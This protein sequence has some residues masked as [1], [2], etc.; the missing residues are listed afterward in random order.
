MLQS[1]RL[2]YLLVSILFIIFLFSSQPLFSQYFNVYRADASEY[3]TVKLF[4]NVHN[5]YLA[6]KEDKINFEDFSVKENGIDMQLFE[7][8]TQ[9]LIRKCEYLEEGIPVSVAF[10]LDASATMKDPVSSGSGIKFDH[11]KEAAK[12]MADS[13]N[14]EG[15]SEAAIVG[16]TSKVIYNN[17][18]YSNR[19]E[20]KDSIDRMVIGTTTD[21]NEVFESVSGKN[22]AKKDGAFKLFES[23]KENT[24]RIII[25]LSDGK[26]ESVGDPFRY[27]EFIQTSI[28][29][30]ITVFAVT[31]S[32]ENYNDLRELSLRTGGDYFQ[33]Q[34]G[35]QLKE[36]YKQLFV[37]LSSGKDKCWLEYT[38]PIACLTGNNTNEVVV[39][40]S[41]LNEVLSS[42]VTYEPPVEKL[43]YIE[44]EK[45]LI[46]FEKTPDKSRVIKVTSV[47]YAAD[48]SFSVEPDDGNFELPAPMTFLKDKQ[49]SLIVKYLGV[50]PGAKE[51]DFIINGEC[52]S[53]EI[54]LV[55][56]GGDAKSE[57][58]FG[59]VSITS[60]S[61]QIVTLTNNGFNSISG[62]LR[63][64]GID[65]SKFSIKAG[66][67]SFDIGPG[68]SHPARITFSPDI[69]GKI[70]KAWLK[71]DSDECGETQVDLI[72]NG[73]DQ[74]LEFTVNPNPFGKQR[75]GS[76]SS[77]KEIL[78]ENIGTKDVVVE[79]IKFADGSY[80]DNFQFSVDPLLDL[81]ITLTSG[82]THPIRVQFIPQNDNGI[83]Y[84]D[85][86]VRDETGI[87]VEG[88]LTG[89]GILPQ[90]DADDRDFGQYNVGVS[91]PV[92]NVVIKNESKTEDLLIDKLTINN[93]PDGDFEFATGQV[94]NN[95]TVA[96]EDEI[97]VDII[98]T[99]QSGGSRSATLDIVHNAVVG[100]ISGRDTYSVDLSGEGIGGAEV[101][102]LNPSTIECGTN[103]SILTVNNPTGNSIDVDL[104]IE[105]N[106]SSAFSFDENSLV[107]SKTITVNGAKEELN[108]YL[109]GGS[110]IGNPSAKIT[111]SSDGL[112][113]DS[114]I[115]NAIRRFDLKMEIANKTELT[116]GIYA[117]GS[118]M[119]IKFSTDVFSA[120]LLAEA[121]NF[122]L[123][124]KANPEQMILPVGGESA[125]ISGVEIALVTP[126][127]GREFRFSLDK[128]NLVGDKIS[129]EIT[130][131]TLLFNI[132]KDEIS[133]KLE[134]PEGP[135][136]NSKED[137]FEINIENCISEFRGG[138]LFDETGVSQ[139]AP[140]PVGDAF[141][142]NYAV[143]IDGE[144]TEIILYDSYGNLVI[145]IYS[146]LHE[147]GFFQ[148]N[149]STKN[150]S[151]GQYFLIFN[152]G[153]RH[154]IQKVMI[155]K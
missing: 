80:N 134:F 99:P 14:F 137:A 139:I 140:N 132:K 10:V 39:E 38:S 103:K 76:V 146:G 149:V 48:V 63:L 1:K 151:N 25:F 49:A 70:Y 119:T 147:K 4:Y 104:I 46:S 142:V 67:E 92:Q 78:I 111:A 11:A 43:K 3:P 127:E 55:I 109:I 29:N 30:R 145:D 102:T 89:I 141:T 8:L 87:E 77:E 125:T 50:N 2:S 26:H 96:M 65:A 116:E 85:I 12:L 15:G 45:S 90:I 105:E 35:Y 88:R 6:V 120:N 112:G 34:S 122:D 73:V 54:K 126:Q 21:F 81:P 100:D 95:L 130:F 108:V 59:D 121:N 152:S 75:V 27:E 7:N 79:N 154:N 98:F 23:A 42:T 69:E 24:R 51:Y 5:G 136:V 57:H 124:I 31:F 143:G 84:T 86:V 131:N 115:I 135:C 148:T 153:A 66:F 64:G 94:V 32:G 53:P 74:V 83:V 52:P 72:G 106:T 97:N 114:E 19:Q 9:N 155:L 150:I 36:I 133:A 40:Y 17:G 91:S 16:F 58:D 60:G 71:F 82:Q 56:C 22:G 144:P 123:L 129:G 37:E 28:E 33:P 107:E 118:E 110:E 113:S 20:L 61:E 93:N 138:L 68:E 62:I 101:I 18:W 47:N 117:P 13:I 41:G 44:A 128:S